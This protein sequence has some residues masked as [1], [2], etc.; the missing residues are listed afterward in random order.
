MPATTGHS[1]AIDGWNGHW[2]RRRRCHRNAIVAIRTGRARIAKTSALPNLPPPLAALVGGGRRGGR[3]R[4]DVTESSVACSEPVA[5]PTPERAPVN[6]QRGLI[7][8]KP[9]LGRKGRVL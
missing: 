8:E 6:H 5:L 7:H 1:R 4:P 3:A 9:L 2:R